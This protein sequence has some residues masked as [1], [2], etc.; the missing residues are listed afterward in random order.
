[1]QDKPTCPTNLSLLH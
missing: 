1:M